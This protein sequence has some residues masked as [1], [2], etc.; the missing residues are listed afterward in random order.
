MRLVQR[1]TLLFSLPFL[2]AGVAESEPQSESQSES[3]H[4]RNSIRRQTQE[5]EPDQLV[6]P[7]EEENRIIG[8]VNADKGEYPFFV[9]FEGGVLCGGSLISPNRV[10]TAGHCIASHGWPKSVRVGSTTKQDGEVIA[11]KCGVL[12]PGYLNPFLTVLADVA[13]LKLETNVT[14]VNASDFVQLNNDGGYPVGND[15]ALT[16]IGYGK[17]S[18]SGSTSSTLRKVGTKFVPRDKCLS[19]YNDAIVRPE[20]HIC[21]DVPNKGDCNGGE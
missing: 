2:V 10:L 9:K 5:A 7:L 3:S 8:G 14:S 21:A 20:A 6:Q 16:V 15:T 11:V 13:I 12:H 4:S 17:I 18:N 19:Y 1:L